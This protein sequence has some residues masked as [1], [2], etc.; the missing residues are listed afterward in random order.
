MGK[1]SDKPRIAKGKYYTPFAALAPL[2]PHLQDKTRFIEPCAGDGRLTHWLAEAGHVCTFACDIEPSEYAANPAPCPDKA[3]MVRTL[4]VCELLITD[5]PLSTTHAITNPPWPLPGAS[6]EPTMSIIKHLLQLNLC[7]WMLLPADF[8][9]NAYAAPLLHQRG[10]RIVSV[11]RVQWFPGT[12]HTAMDNCCW[13]QFAA[14]RRI[15]ERGPI[16][17]PRREARHGKC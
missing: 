2:L 14:H 10:M 12:K 7:C 3:V 16:F 17:F 9:H 13:Y 1:R 5:I 6:G 4:D 11:G 15:G 8:M